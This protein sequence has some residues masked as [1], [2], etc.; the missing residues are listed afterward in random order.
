MPTKAR[1][2][3]EQEKKEVKPEPLQEVTPGEVPYTR[4][5]LRG[6]ME[7]SLL[8]VAGQ[9][10]KDPKGFNNLSDQAKGIIRIAFVTLGE[11]QAKLLWGIFLAAKYGEE[12]PAF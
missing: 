10:R 7:Q 1:R 6:I 11:D 9:I 5:G 8:D 4:D 2:Q 12:L 3:K